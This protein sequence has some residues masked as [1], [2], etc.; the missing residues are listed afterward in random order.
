MF[1]LQSIYFGSKEALKLDI[2]NYGKWYKVKQTRARAAN[3]TIVS[4]ANKHL[5]TFIPTNKIPLDVYGF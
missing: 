3:S 2:M 5:V 4:G 1:D